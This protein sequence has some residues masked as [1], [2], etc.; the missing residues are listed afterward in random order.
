MKTYRS[1]HPPKI[2]TIKEY[3]MGMQMQNLRKSFQT[4]WVSPISKLIFPTRGAIF[5]HLC[6]MTSNSNWWF[7]NHWSSFF[8]NLWELPFQ[9]KCF[10]RVWN[11]TSKEPIQTSHENQQLESEKPYP[12][13]RSKN[14]SILPNS[15][16]TFQPPLPQEQ[17][18]TPELT[19][20]FTTL[21]IL[22]TTRDPLF[23]WKNRWVATTLQ[24]TIR[25]QTLADCNHPAMKPASFLSSCRECFFCFLWS[26][27]S[28]GQW[29]E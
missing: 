1:I 18:K 6:L 21:F 23:S 10:F 25:P 26:F 16:C 12:L 24:G 4:L 5:I 2:A 22:L 13:G 17:T 7:G 11:K 8:W 19:L 20:L 29:L 3:M 14:K 9:K 28:S 15:S 27:K